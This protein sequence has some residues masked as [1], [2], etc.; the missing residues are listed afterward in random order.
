MYEDNHL[1]DD[2]EDRYLILDFYIVPDSW[3]DGDNSGNY[4]D[5][6]NSDEEDESDETSPNEPETDNPDDFI[7][8]GQFGENDQFQDEQDNYRRSLQASQFGYMI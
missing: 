8:I 6:F 7:G 5:M 2:Y 3:Y 4:D 1:E